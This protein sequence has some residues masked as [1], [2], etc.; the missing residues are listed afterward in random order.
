MS[1]DE[2][3]QD[4]EDGV[5]LVMM[6]ND[7]LKQMDNPIAKAIYVDKYADRREYVKC[8]ICGKKYTRWNQA[9]H[10][11]TQHHKTMEHLNDKLRDFLMSK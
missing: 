7:K 2:T 6:S 10:R 8:K 5:E 11:N 3:L 1:F 4:I 9:H